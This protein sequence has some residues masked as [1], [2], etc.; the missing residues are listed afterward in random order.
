MSPHAPHSVGHR[1]STYVRSQVHKVPAYEAHDQCPRSIGTSKRGPGRSLFPA[2]PSPGPVSMNSN[3]PPY[4]AFNSLSVFRESLPQAFPVQGHLGAQGNDPNPFGSGW[5][6]A[7]DPIEDALG[8]S[9]T[10]EPP[11]SRNFVTQ[12]QDSPMLTNWQPSNPPGG[13]VPDVPCLMTPAPV[14]ESL[15]RGNDSILDTGGTTTAAYIPLC[16][17]T[18]Q[19]KVLFKR[20]YTVVKKI[21]RR[22]MLPINCEENGSMGKNSKF[23]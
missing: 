21:G 3:P 9:G 15:L 4:E 2:Q 12:C 1:P 8:D 20:N 22:T 10:G 6:R 17:Y 16:G 18:K 23:Y 5:E 13:R 11:V 7:P 14:Q 19:S